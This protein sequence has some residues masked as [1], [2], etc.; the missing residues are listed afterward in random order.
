MISWVSEYQKCQSD[1]AW[2]A[3]EHAGTFDILGKDRV[4]MLQGFCTADIDKLPEHQGTEAFILNP[5]G[6]TLAL[7]RVFKLPDRLWIHCDNR[8]VTPLVQH[9]DRYVIREDVEFDERSELRTEH[10]AAGPNAANYLASQ[11]GLSLPDDDADVACSVWQRHELRIIKTSEFGLP[12]FRI[13]I[14]QSSGQALAAEL[15]EAHQVTDDVGNA[16]RMEKGTPRSGLDITKDN[17]PQ[18]LH[19]DSTAISFTKGCY[20]GQ[21]TVARIDALGHVNRLLVG[22]TFEIGAKP[23][24]GMELTQGDKSV[25]FVTSAT[26]SPQHEC[27]LAL[28]FLRRGIHQAGT[29]VHSSEGDATVVEF[30]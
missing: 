1:W 24:P 17:L 16:L 12:A 11:L 3:D 30:D 21:E 26:Y 4:R 8:N 23:Q 29:V 6:K 27:M 13:D 22:L 10:V 25:G 9:L 15:G 18:E 7:V 28:G 2:W 20:L 19:R 14:A 5:K